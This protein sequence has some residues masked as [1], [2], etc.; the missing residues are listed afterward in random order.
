MKLLHVAGAAAFSVVAFTVG[1]LAQ[2]PASA[3]VT[4]EIAPMPEELA[5][6]RISGSGITV[7]DLDGMRQWYETVLNMHTVGSY[8]RNGEIFEYILSTSPERDGGAV[9]ALLKGNRRDGA[10]TYGRLILAAPDADA[11]ADY[12]RNHGVAARRV[13]EGAYFITDPEGNSVELYTPPAE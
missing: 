8:E 4:G 9:L 5:P 13:A 10:T 1:V 12:L 2:P 3:L 11:A 6:T 7:T